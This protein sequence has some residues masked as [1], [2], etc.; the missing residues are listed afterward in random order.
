MEDDKFFQPLY[1]TAV[2]FGVSP[3]WL[4]IEAKAGRVP[5]LKMGNRILFNQ[6]LV[7]ESLLARAQ[8]L[9]TPNE[10]AHA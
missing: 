9:R 6:K 2:H 5:H 7:E 10:V 4:L 3:A 8:S 1:R